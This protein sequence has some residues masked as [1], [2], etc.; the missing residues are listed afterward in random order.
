MN[1]QTEK[2]VLERFAELLRLQDEFTKNYI[3][4]HEIIGAIRGRLDIALSDP[5]PQKPASPINLDGEWEH[6]ASLPGSYR[7]IKGD[8]VTIISPPGFPCLVVTEKLADGFRAVLLSEG[9]GGWRKRAATTDAS[10]PAP[11]PD[12]RVKVIDRES[13][14]V[15]HAAP[16]PSA[17]AEEIVEKIVVPRI[18]WDGHDKIVFNG[19]YTK[20]TIIGSSLS[21][22]PSGF[23]EQVRAAVAELILE[24]IHQAG[25]A[26]AARFKA[27]VEAA[28]EARMRLANFQPDG[29]SYV[30]DAAIAAAEKA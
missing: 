25:E 21:Q 28:K 8:E 5:S 7:I 14:V 23:I 13:R 30:L 18:R 24:G 3:Q 9:H 15:T 4:S 16:A 10:A 22:T 17:S 20:T 12:D 26:Q 6:S 19:K 1:T 29:A 27:L 2:T 11:K